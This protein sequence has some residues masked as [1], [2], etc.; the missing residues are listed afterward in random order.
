[1]IPILED[2]VRIYLGEDCTMPLPWRSHPGG[3]I[4]VGAFDAAVDAEWERSRPRRMPRILCAPGENPDAVPFWALWTAKESL[5]KLEWRT[6]RF[7][8]ADFPVTGWRESAHPNPNVLR[9]F[10]FDGGFSALLHLPSHFAHL[11]V[12]AALPGLLPREGADS[13]SK[14]KGKEI[15]PEHPASMGNLFLRDRVPTPEF[16]P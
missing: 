13:E 3:G 2:P 10:L 4:V 1:M 14:A 8:P 15:C 6:R 12:S 9:F 7:V 5:Y 16:D 11:W